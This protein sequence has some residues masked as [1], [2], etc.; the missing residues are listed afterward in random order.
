MRLELGQVIFIDDMEYVVKGMI[1]FQ[2]DSW[3]WEEYKIVANNGWC[4]WLSIEMED[5]RPV[6]SLYLDRYDIPQYPGMEIVVDGETY[7]ME[8]KG[9]SIVTGYFGQ[10]DVD[11]WEKCKYTEYVNAGRDKFVSYEDWD[12]ELEKSTGVLLKEEQVRITDE[13]RA[14]S[15]IGYGNMSLGGDFGGS[16]FGGG[17]G[18]S[19]EGGSRRS[20]S[21]FTEK[22]IV[23]AAIVIFATPILSGVMSGLKSN[24][25]Q[26][27]LES[28]GYFTYV[29]SVTNSENNKKA[30]VY[31]TDLTIEEAVKKII[32]N[33]PEQISSVSEVAKEEGEEGDDSVGL[34][35]SKEYAFVYLSEEGSTYVQVSSKNYVTSSTE[36]YGSRYHRRRYYRTYYAGSY[37]NTNTTY[38][39]YLNSARQSSVNS[40]TSSGGGTSYGK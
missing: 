37:G 6:Y 36:A 22:F 3:E 40:R 14:V 16:S 21:T 12:G 1:A 2:E 38:T 10:V 35:T 23:L 39:N 9:A 31:K 24:H 29:T 33:V 17:S 8:E 32:D 18:M 20:N 27:Y 28:S 26:S 13:R 30:K 11:K 25:I 15:N 19:F 7:E 34:N 4:Q 5:G